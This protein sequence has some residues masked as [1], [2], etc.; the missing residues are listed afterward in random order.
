MS[1][2]LR[3]GL[4]QDGSSS[5][6]TPAKVFSGVWGATERLSL[7]LVAPEIPVPARLSSGVAGGLVALGLAV[8]EILVDVGGDLGSSD[9]NMALDKFN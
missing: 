5:G 4:G 2:F 8:P 1:R 6:K 7:W 3:G 9:M